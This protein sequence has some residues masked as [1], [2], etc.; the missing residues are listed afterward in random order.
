MGAALQVSGA[1]HARLRQGSLGGCGRNPEGK[2]LWGFPGGPVVKNAPCKAGP[3]G[4]TPGWE[5]RPHCGGAIKSEH[6]NY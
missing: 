1:S 6:H 4:S 5:L 3:V 2:Q